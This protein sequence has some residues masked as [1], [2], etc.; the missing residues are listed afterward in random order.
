M[1]S[2]LF[3]RDPPVDQGLFGLEDNREWNV[4]AGCFTSLQLHPPPPLL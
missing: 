2:V 4:H 3:H 1:R